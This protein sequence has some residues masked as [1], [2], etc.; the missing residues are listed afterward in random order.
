MFI[1]D[2]R[3]GG[4]VEH[5]LLSPDE[6]TVRLYGDAAPS[7]ITYD[8]SLLTEWVKLT[9]RGGSG[10]S[11]GWVIQELNR[12]LYLDLVHRGGFEPRF[13]DLLEVVNPTT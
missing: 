12:W 10:K 5:P 2:G 7:A 1:R 9:Q 4:V 3:D 6:R 11:E 8:L 13:D